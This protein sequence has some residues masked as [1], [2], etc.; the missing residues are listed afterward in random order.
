MTVT[1]S[2]VPDYCE[3]M[4]NVAKKF[5]ENKGSDNET[6]NTEDSSTYNSISEALR[7]NKRTMAA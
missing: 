4:H 1:V 7:G 5:H 2:G 3:K 6:E